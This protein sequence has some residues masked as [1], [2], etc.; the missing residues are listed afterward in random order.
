MRSVLALAAAALA[1]CASPGRGP[2]VAI[3]WPDGPEDRAPVAVQGLPAEELRALAL[4]S[5]TLAVFVETGED[6]PPVSGKWRVEGGALLFEPRYAWTANLPYR[7][8]FRSE[9]RGELVSAHTFVAPAPPSTTRVTA[10]YPSAGVLP[11]NVLRVYVHFDAPM[12][13]GEA[14]ERVHVL[15]EDGRPLSEPFIP[16][17]EE[18]WDPDTTRLTLLFDPGRIKRGLVPNREQGAPLE[19][20]RSY[21]LVIDADWR[22][23]AG[24]PLAAGFERDFRTT[25]PDREQPDLDAWRLRPPAAG[26]RDALVV[27]LGEPL[28]HALLGRL[29]TVRREPGVELAGEVVVSAAETRWSFRPVEP[30]IAGGH[31]L[32]VDPLLEDLAGNSLL[33]PF[34]VDLS[35]ETGLPA[36]PDDFVRTFT[37]A[38]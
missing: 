31:R 23:A 5:A 21:T 22:D 9:E 12:R 33:R 37:I 38:P 1:A 32:V 17:Q 14:Y 13:R 4:D 20:G 8:R 24:A 30:W 18:L 27:E 10:V 29:L 7:A 34:E 35:I 3:V 28:D 2:R 6:A 11:Q 26:T 16:F 25:A 19:G 36:S 15:D